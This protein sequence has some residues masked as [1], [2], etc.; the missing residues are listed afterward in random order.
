M[1][2]DQSD[3]GSWVGR[4]FG[5]S[6]LLLGTALAIQAAVDILEAVW[7]PLSLLILVTLVIWSVV[8]WR[9]RF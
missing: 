7:V 2:T 1:S 8:A 4:L 9:R 3:P 5:W 6:L